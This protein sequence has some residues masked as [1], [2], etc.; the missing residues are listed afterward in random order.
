M[1]VIQPDQQGRD[2]KIYE[3]E[4]ESSRAGKI[5]GGL[6]VVIAGLLILAREINI[7][8]PDWAFSWQMLVISIGVFMAFKHGFKSFFWLILILIG[9]VFIIRDYVP[10]F[11][12]RNLIWPL[13]LIALGLY[14]VFKPRRSKCGHEYR[15]ARFERFKNNFPE[16]SVS[17]D[18]FIEINSVFGGVERV[19]VSKNF[20]GGEIN[21]VFGGAEINLSQ[22]ELT[23][24]AQLELNAVFGGVRLVIPPHWVLQ[25]ELTAFMGGVEDKR[26]ISRDTN[27]QDEKILVLKGHAVFGGIEVQ[28]Y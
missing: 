3:M 2:S 7:P 16:G 10:G 27:T 25:S 4:N 17:G 15:K 12:Y 9:V 20:K 26:P 14:I 21:T 19:I 13:A 22:A 5:V 1:E 18:D 6:L 28:S 11:Q 23:D 8:V 24:R